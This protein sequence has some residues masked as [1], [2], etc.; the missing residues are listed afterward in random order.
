ML[1]KLFFLIYLYLTLVLFKKPNEG[2]FKQEGLE[3]G[4][5]FYKYIFIILLKFELIKIKF[6]S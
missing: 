6:E 1:L 5:A 2:V 4:P 3:F